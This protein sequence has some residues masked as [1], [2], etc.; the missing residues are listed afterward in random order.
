MGAAEQRALELR[1]PQGGALKVQVPEI[2][3]RRVEAAI[4]LH[5]VICAEDA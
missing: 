5:L 4:V 3:P 1:V 2:D